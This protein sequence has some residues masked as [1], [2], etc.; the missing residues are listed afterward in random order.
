[1]K[2]FLFVLLT[3]IPL[4]VSAGDSTPKVIAEQFLASLPR[5]RYEAS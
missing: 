3:W 5:G 2:E 1:M 4:S